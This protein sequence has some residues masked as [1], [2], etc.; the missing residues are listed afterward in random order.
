MYD[1]PELL[2]IHDGSAHHRFFLQLQ[3]VQKQLPSLHFVK[4]LLIEDYNVEAPFYLSEL[5]TSPHKT[6]TTSTCYATEVIT[7]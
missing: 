5:K 6:L 3:Q 1:A 2:M 4:G 7:R